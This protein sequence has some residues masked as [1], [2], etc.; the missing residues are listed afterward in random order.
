MSDHE[1]FQ[2]YFREYFTVY[3]GYCQYKFA[4]DLQV[5]K[6]IVQEAFIRLWVNRERLPGELPVRAYM[7]KMIV[8]AGLNLLKHEKN[9]E[10]YRQYFLQNTVS[11]PTTDM[12]SSTDFNTLQAT[13]NKAIAS[14]PAQM[15]T[16]F[17]L[18]RDNGLTYRQIAETL[19]VSVKTVETQMSRALE[20]LRIKL[21]R[22]LTL[23]FLVAIILS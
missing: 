3:S 8:N 14:L 15:R 1:A 10:K 18:S 12:F 20:K 7:N 21:G 19:Q 23:L 4:F 16:I 17:L 11:G 22:Y 5:S 2:K 13:V 6:E 9:K